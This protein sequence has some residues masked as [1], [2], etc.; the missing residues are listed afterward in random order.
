[1]FKPQG[2]IGVVTV[3]TVSVIALA[4]AV[5]SAYLSIDEILSSFAS[6]QSQQALHL[7]DG[8]AEEAAF[9]LKRNAAYTGGTIPF[10]GG[11]CSVVVSGSGSTRTITSTVIVGEY[12]RAVQTQVTFTTN[13]AT[14][15]DGIDVTAWEEQ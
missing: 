14:N 1:M 5:T 6:D 4:L 3:M 2:F 7:A 12:T 15:A 8:C 13:V 11:T 10:T 9:R